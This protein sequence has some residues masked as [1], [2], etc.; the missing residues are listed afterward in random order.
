MFSQPMAGVT[1]EEIAAVRE[2]A[3]EFSSRKAMKS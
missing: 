3:V 2:K 1:Q